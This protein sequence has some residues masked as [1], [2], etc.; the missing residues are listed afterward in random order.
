[1][2]NKFVSY[3]CT[4]CG[5]TMLGHPMEC[6]PVGTTA[7]ELTCA[8]CSVKPVTFA[9]LRFFDHQGARLANFP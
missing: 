7:V 1:M 4:K 8:Y 9:G 5:T 6:A 3:R 2:S